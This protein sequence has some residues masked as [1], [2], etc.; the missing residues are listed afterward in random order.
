MGRTKGCEWSPEEDERLTRL[1]DGGAKKEQILVEFPDRT[2]RA[3]Y[4]HAGVLGLVHGMCPRRMWSFL[5][6]VEALEKNGPMTQKQLQEATG[7]SAGTVYARTHMAFDRGWL[8]AE[9]QPKAGR[10]DN[11]SVWSVGELPEIRRPKIIK[12]AK[13][14]RPV[15]LEAIPRRDPMVAALFGSA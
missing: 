13:E 2:E 14:R 7:L 4:R 3:I 9:K 10:G 5:R 12:S 6:I 15:K 11:P 1:F 8:L